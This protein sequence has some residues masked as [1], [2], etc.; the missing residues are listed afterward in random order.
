MLFENSN[1]M[2]HKIW[3]M[4]QRANFIAVKCACRVKI[5]SF[6]QGSDAFHTKTYEM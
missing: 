1:F 2:Q 3:F 6:M 5:I 4:E